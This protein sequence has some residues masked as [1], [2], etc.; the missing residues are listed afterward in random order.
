MILMKNRTPYKGYT[1]E[2][3]RDFG[4]RGFLINGKEVKKGYVVVGKHGTNAMPSAT[5]FQTIK[6]AKKG[7]N[8]LEKYG[9]KG[10]WKG[11]KKR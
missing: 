6:E 2:P 4:K 9:K 8:V 1:I 3:K 5:W 11:W 7:I 10:F